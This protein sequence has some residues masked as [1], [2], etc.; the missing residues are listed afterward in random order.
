MNPPE[1]FSDE[2]FLV[3]NGKKIHRVKNGNALYFSYASCGIGGN[4]YGVQE[5]FYSKCKTCRKM[6]SKNKEEGK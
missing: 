1:Q 4:I 5:S 2:W 6:E 3:G